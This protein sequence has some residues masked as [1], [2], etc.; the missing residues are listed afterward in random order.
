MFAVLR[1]SSLPY[2]FQEF[3]EVIDSGGGML[4][5]TGKIQKIHYVNCWPRFAQKANDVSVLFLV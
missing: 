3:A 4:N 1:P 2:K 5:F